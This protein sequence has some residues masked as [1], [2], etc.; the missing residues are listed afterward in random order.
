[1]RSHIIST[2]LL[3]AFAA[4]M[5]VGYS[6]TASAGFAC[7]KRAEVVYALDKQF[8]EK[9]RISGLVGSDAVL[10][11]F[12][13]PQGTWTIV[14]TNV[15]GISCITAAGNEWQDMPIEVAELDS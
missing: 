11:I 1:M 9:R 6:E 4:V 14:I 2:S 15:K 10:E 8:N 12:I 5:V 13:S 3:S 7:G